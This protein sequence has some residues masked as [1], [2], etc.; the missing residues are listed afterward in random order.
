MNS[1]HLS[2]DSITRLKSIIIFLKSVNA[3]ISAHVP[4]LPF[5]ISK[6]CYRYFGMH[7]HTQRA[8]G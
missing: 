2:E 4:E 1:D 8:P 3:L 6:T 5:T 7:E